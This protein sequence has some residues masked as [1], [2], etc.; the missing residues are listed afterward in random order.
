MLCAFG[1]PV[2]TCCDVLCIVGSNLTIFKL[3]TISNMSQHIATQ[4]PN[5]HNTLRPT[6]LVYVALACCDRLAGALSLTSKL[7]IV[8]TRA[9]P[10]FEDL[11]NTCIRLL[12]A[13]FTYWIKILCIRLLKK[14]RLNSYWNWHPCNWLTYL[15][16]NGN[17]IYYSHTVLL[18]FFMK[19]QR[20]VCKEICSFYCEVNIV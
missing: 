15:F 3:E 8:F 17:E 12:P 14:N 4:W 16:V 20:I 19:K 1:H 2:A 5:A 10:A 9:A 6:M 13:A 18:L 11:F 7:A